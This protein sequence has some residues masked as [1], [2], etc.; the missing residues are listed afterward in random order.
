MKKVQVR[1][2]N[3]VVLN[4]LV[5]KATVTADPRDGRDLFWLHRNNPHIVCV[6]NYNV[7]THPEGFEKF[8]PVSLSAQG[9][10]LLT[11]H[12]ISRTCDHSGLWVSYWTDGYTEGDAGKKFVHCHRS[13]LVAGLRTLVEMKLGSEVE[14]PDAIFT[15]CRSPYCEC[16]VGECKIEG[17]V[18]ARGTYPPSESADENAPS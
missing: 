7:S 13:E 11:E 15:V 6:I 16:T 12:R 8:Y 1:D 4:W 3:G 14:V 5:A 10:P 18:D 17:H 9:H 2:A